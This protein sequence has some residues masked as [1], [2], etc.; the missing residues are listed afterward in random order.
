VEASL[1]VD[2]SADVGEGC[3]PGPGG[4]DAPL[5]DFLTTAH[6][7]CGG[8]AG[9]DASMRRLAEETLGAGVVL[10]AHPSY[11]DREGFGRR[12]MDELDAD[13]VAAAVAE[14][15]GR[16]VSIA[17]DVGAAVR[18][19]KPHGALYE[20]V[21]RDVT[22]AEAIARRLLALEA[23]V[24]LVLPAGARSTP[25]VQSM[26]IAV[27]SEAFCDRGYRS[28]GSLV[29]RDEPGALVTE[30][31]LAS[32]RALSIVRDGRI[33]AVSGEMIEIT[34]TTLCIHGDTPG[35]LTIAANVRRSLERAGVQVAALAS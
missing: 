14:Q 11:P 3:G 18:S 24:V 19:V 5:L 34:A 27:A 6:V 31:D 15:V 28:D 8:H 12:A 35:A 29:S 2:L 17:V 21:A 1:R 20:R 25:V 10:G 13:D 7:A 16:L 23:P 26:G 33:E 9:D 32:A 30:P 22:S 4:D